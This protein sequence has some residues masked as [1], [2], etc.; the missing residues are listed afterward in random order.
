MGTCDAPASVIP[1]TRGP[2]DVGGPRE[3]DSRGELDD[4]HDEGPSEHEIYV[5]TV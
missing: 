1:L 2:G 4:K 5:L 3:V